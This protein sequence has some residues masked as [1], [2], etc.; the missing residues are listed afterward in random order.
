MRSH[1][2]GFE[3][4]ICRDRESRRG[5]GRK[6]AQRVQEPYAHHVSPLDSGRHAGDDEHE[7]GQQLEE[8][9]QDHAALGV[10][11]IFGGQRSL[12][13]HLSLMELTT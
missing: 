5:G 2:S 4:A 13:D 11:E 8:A 1:F 3:Q 12:D 9:G 10:R 6:H 7:E